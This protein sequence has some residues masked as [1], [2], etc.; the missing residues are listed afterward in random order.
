MPLSRT[1]AGSP[2]AP[3][4]I[5]TTIFAGG[6]PTAT[7]SSSSGSVPIPIGAIIG[8]LLG[9]VFLALAAI[10]GWIWWGKLIERKRRKEVTYLTPTYF[11]QSLTLRMARPQPRL[12]SALK[13]DGPSTTSVNASKHSLPRTHPMA[14]SQK[15]VSFAPVPSSR[16]S[17]ESVLPQT[18]SPGD[19]SDVYNNGDKGKQTPR[20]AP[21]TSP[22]PGPTRPRTPPLPRGSLRSPSSLRGQNMERAYVPSRPSPL[23]HATHPPSSTRGRRAIVHPVVDAR[24]AS[25]GLQP[26]LLKA[27]S[28]YSQE[29]TA[30][31]VDPMLRPHDA[32]LYGHRQN[33]EPS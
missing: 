29:G 9:G 2:R 21:A 28:Q 31:E 30:S 19:S 15:S 25:Q 33:D 27:P 26:T 6:G 4:I 12:R 16:S 8:G 18:P 1:F 3:Q 24:P 22:S 11:S 32:R 20:K 5:T 10:G 7:S 13:K 14:S 23:S 17:E